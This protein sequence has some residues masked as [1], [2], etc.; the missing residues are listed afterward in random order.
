MVWPAPVMEYNANN[1]SPKGRKQGEYVQSTLGPYDYWAIEYAYKPIDAAKEK[2]ELLKIASRSKEPLL[3]FANDL[4][5]GLG[6]VEGM[7]PQVTRRDLGS[8]PLAFAERRMLLSR[9]LIDRLQDRTLKPGEQFDN[10]RRN[11]ISANAQIALATTVATKYVGGVVH[12]RDHADSG[13]AALNPVPAATQRKA[14]K[15]VTDSLFR[16]ESFKLKPEFVARLVPDQFDRWFST[17][18]NLSAIVNPDASISGAVLALQRGALDHL[19][20]DAVA[21][22]RARCAVEDDGCQTGDGFVGNLR[23]GARRDLE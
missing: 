13:R 16:A 20:S 3:A 15:L 10:L 23:H 8:D 5:A 2:D 12:Y 9:E 22:A 19:M 14:L 21:R 7:D 4:D 1:I 6:N 17:S 11:F 18:N